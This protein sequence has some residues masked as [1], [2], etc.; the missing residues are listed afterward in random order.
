[1]TGGLSPGASL[2]DT[3]PAPGAYFAGIKHIARDVT[4][5][6]S[7]RTLPVETF[8]SGYSAIEYHTLGYGERTYSLAL[9]GGVKLTDELLFGLSLSAEVR[10]LHLRYARDTA[11]ENGRGPGGITSDCG[12]APCGVENPAAA[13]IYD[14]QV[15]SEVSTD[16]LVAN[17]GLLYILAKDMYLAVSYHASPGLAVQNTL[18]GDMTVTRSPRDGGA[19]LR[20]DASVIV[21]EPA[22]VDAEYRTRLPER[23]DLHV[24]FRWEDL[25]RMSA[26]DVRGFGSTFSTNGIP[27]WTERARGFHDPFALWAGVEQ[28]EHGETWRF[29]GR[30]G[31]ETSAVDTDQTSPTAIAPISLTTDIGVHLRLSPTLIVEGTYGLQYFAGVHVRGS[32]Y[33]PRDRIECVESSYDYST[34][35]CQAVRSGFAIASADGDYQKIEHAFRLALRVMIP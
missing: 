28:V 19:L 15:R 27:E 14:V 1:M 33:D 23:L 22:S 6:I 30:L 12:G 9:G 21:Q 5:A 25:S 10:T 8:P 11:L 35:A 2:H 34:T 31:F 13:E 7:A 24:G 26:Y 18:T 17:I 32:A 3:S 4:V 29:G 20:G 16:A